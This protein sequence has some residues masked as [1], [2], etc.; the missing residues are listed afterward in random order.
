M[1]TGWLKL[2]GLLLILLGESL[3]INLQ[4]HRPSKSQRDFW[5]CVLV[6][7]F[8][9]KIGETVLAGL[10]KLPLRFTPRLGVYYTYSATECS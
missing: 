3:G 10:R 7:P 6:P 8:P 9:D 5:V 1:S 2:I 4:S